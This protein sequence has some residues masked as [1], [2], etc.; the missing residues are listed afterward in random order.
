[1]SSLAGKLCNYPHYSN[2]GS[3]ILSE[4]LYLPDISVCFKVNLKYICEFLLFLKCW[5]LEVLF[6]WY[7]DLTKNDTLNAFRE[8]GYFP[9]HSLIS[10][11]S[12]VPEGISLFTD[13][14]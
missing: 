14:F 5:P 13:F 9:Q 12:P 10:H 6:D 1:M 4:I 7:S 8:D 2:R 11:D 3:Q